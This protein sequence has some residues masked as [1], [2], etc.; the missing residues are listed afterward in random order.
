MISFVWAGKDPFWAGRG[1]SEN[2]TAGQVRELMRRG[3]PTRIITVGFGENDGRDGF[4]D[5]AFKSIKTQDELRN[6]DDI[7]VGV[8]YPIAVPTRRQAYVILH[9][10]LNSSLGRDPLFNLEAVSH[11]RMLAASRFAAKMWATT[12]H[13]RPG[14]IPAVYP[15]AETVFSQVQRPANTS[16]KVRILFGS[17]LTV[18]KGIYTLLAALHMPSMA[19]IEYEITTTTAASNTGQGPVI[20]KLLE[21]HPLIKMVEARRS[22]KEMAK[23]MA[24]HDIL[25]MPSSD[26]YWKEIFGIVSVEAQHAGCRVVASNAGG[27]PE[28]DCGGLVLVKPDDPQALANGLARAAYLGPLTAAERMYA[29]SKF[30]VGASVDKLLAIMAADERRQP[31]LQKQGT[32]VRQQLDFAINTISELGLRVAGDKQ[33]S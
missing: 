28:T 32:L 7:L 30:T 10:P 17:R 31:L 4:P 15:F 1:G 13:M 9:C 25:V 33:P 29:T 24:E 12:M 22:P 11:A 6:L 5:I 8:T 16:K 20:R 21:V 2:Y 23:L 18:D 14:K 19:D 3:I 26:I 27:I